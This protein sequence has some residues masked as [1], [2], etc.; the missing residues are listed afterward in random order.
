MTLTV[1]LEISHLQENQG[2]SETTVNYAIDVLDLFAV[3]CPIQDKDLTAPP[4]GEA[5][6]QAWI[7]GASPT[8]TWTGHAGDIAFYKNSA[9]YFMNPQEGWR[10]YL[11]DENLTYVYDGAAWGIA[12]ATPT[13]HATSHK[14]GGSDEVATATPAANAIPKAGAGGTLDNGWLDAEL[15]AIAGLTSAANKLPR[16]T[17][18]GTADLLDFDTDT[19]LAANSDTRIASQKAVKAYVDLA[20]TGLL[21]FK[22]ATDASSNPNYPA[23]SKGDTYVVSVAGKVGGASGKSVDVGDMYVATAD[24]AGGTEASVGTSWVVLEHNLQG[25]LLSANNLSDVA[26]AATSRTNLGLVIGTN[27]QAQDAE[28]SA[29]AGLTSAADSL[30]YFTGSGTAALATLTAAARTVLDDATVSAMLD[31]LG[32]ASATGT[33]GIVRADS[34]SITTLLTAAALTLS[35]TLKLTGIASVTASTTQ[36]QGQQALTA[37]INIVTTGS[38]NDVVTLPA[39]VAG[40]ICIIRNKSST[41]LQVFPASG[42]QINAL[43]VDASYSVISTR[44]LLCIAADSTTWWL[45]GFAAI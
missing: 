45:L 27:V 18:S 2:S 8:G 19:T 33:G 22:G 24:N 9:Y 7:V 3:G 20:V 44:G 4:G 30:P 14:H 25:A 26:S 32:G 13:A 16:F 17:G 6:G 36:T 5:D 38:N 23:A 35:G 11:R 28:L 37:L 42:D 15:G 10:A 34:P 1:H 12:T 43:A 29:L 31:T 21:D 41:N 40:Q 39:A